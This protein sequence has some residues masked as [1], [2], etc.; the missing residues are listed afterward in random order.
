MIAEAE[1][2]VPASG[3][4]TSSFFIKPLDS[5][6]NLVPST[7]GV[8]SPTAKITGY[9]L[10][11]GI[12]PDNIQAMAGISFPSSPSVGQ[13]VLRTDYL[14][15]RLF[16]WNGAAWV[17]IEDV[18]RTDLTQGPNNKTLLSTFLNNTDSFTNGQGQTIVSKQS[19]SDALR[20]R[21]DNL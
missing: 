9:L 20:P 3:Y 14:P 11:D 15:N 5:G 8:N 21:P 2:D 6:G 7:G 18:Q 4:D 16:Q 19:L 12:P 17:K 1:S 10:G 13:F